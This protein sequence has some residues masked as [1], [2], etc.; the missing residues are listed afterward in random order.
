MLQ[1][2]VKRARDAH[3]MAKG[4]HER[5]VW[6]A[7]LLFNY[8]GFK[9]MTT[10]SPSCPW[11]GGE[12]ELGTKGRHPPLFKHARLQCCACRPAH[13]CV[14]CSHLHALGGVGEHELGAEGAQQ[15]APL[16][17]HGRRHGQDLLT[18]WKK[19][20]VGGRGVVARKHRGVRYAA[21]SEQQR[22]Q[23]SVG[24]SN[25]TPHH[26]PACSPWRRR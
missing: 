5:G 19:S 21:S 22:Q 14:C 4:V 17:R 20:A 9:L 11:R 16:Q 23:P 25:K 18:V 24:L 3:M 26:S 7:G 10:S 15:D 12:R 8:C 2:L 6:L 13:G 1:K